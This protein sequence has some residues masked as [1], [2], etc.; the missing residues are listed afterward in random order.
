M[1]DLNLLWHLIEQGRKGENKGLS[2]GLPK[3][4]KIIGGIQ[5][6]RYY[7][8]SGASSAGKTALVL[9]FIYRLLRIILKNLYILFILVW[10]LVLKYY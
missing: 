4:D 6:S 3:L 7:C 9:Y 1:E 2:V 8:I 5:P 10:K